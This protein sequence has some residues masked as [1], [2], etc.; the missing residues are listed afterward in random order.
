[1]L[2]LMDAPPRLTRIAPLVSA[3][4]PIAGRLFTLNVGLNPRSVRARVSEFSSMWRYFTS[5]TLLDPGNQFQTTVATFESPSVSVA[6]SGVSLLP[7]PQSVQ[8]FGR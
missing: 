4:N 5:R 1:M 6:V 2:S 8:L 3:K 7:T